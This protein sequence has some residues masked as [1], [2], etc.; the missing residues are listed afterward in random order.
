ME[1]FNA[2][3]AVRKRC[4]VVG[5]Y[6]GAGNAEAATVGINGLSRGSEWGEPGYAGEFFNVFEGGV[7]DA[8][9]GVLGNNP[10]M[11]ALKH[12]FRAID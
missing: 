1:T 2:G 10:I 6:A 4:R 11:E 8:K 12:I 3:V 7:F 9:V 5:K